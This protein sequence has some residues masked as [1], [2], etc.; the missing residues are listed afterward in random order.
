MDTSEKLMPNNGQAVSQPEYSRVI[1]YLMYVMTCTRRDI[2]FV[3]GRLSRYTSNPI[4]QHWQAIQ[5]VLKY[6]KKTMDYSLTYTSYS[7]VL[8]GYTN[9]SCI[10]NTEDNSFTIAAGKEAEWLRNLVLEISLWYKPITPISIRCNSAATLEKAYSQMYNE[11]SRH[12]GVRHNMIRKLIMNGVI[13][14]EFGRS[15][16][17]FVD[18][19]T[20][21]LARDLVTKSA[22][23]MRLK[24]NQVAE[25]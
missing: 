14:I 1:G 25:C 11:K 23:G 24:S 13:S 9:A 7:L 17:N 3:V 18:H 6:L 5:K 2:A 8:K 21:K 20:K 15:Q 12:L 10:S 4:T 22:K 19:L 16:Q